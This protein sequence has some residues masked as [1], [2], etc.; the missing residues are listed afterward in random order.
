MIYLLA[1]LA[2]IAG[3]VIGYFGAAAIGAALAAAFRMSSFEGAS[4]YFVAFVAGPIGAIA[5]L[6]LG[7]YLVLRYYGGITGFPALAGRMAL[8]VAA[9]GTVATGGIWLRLA[10][11]D[12][13]IN[14]AKP[15]LL[16]ELRFPAGFSPDK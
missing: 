16:F 13:F 2:G 15:Q 4:G 12:P 10:T 6:V 7:M 9:I 1:L 11:L 14:Q 3:T 8:I 5:G